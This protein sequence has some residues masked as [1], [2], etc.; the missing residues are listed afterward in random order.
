MSGVRGE[1]REIDRE[2]VTGKVCLDLA[3][4]GFHAAVRTSFCDGRRIHAIDQR[5]LQEHP[6]CVDVLGLCM[7][8][9][10]CAA[11]VLDICVLQLEA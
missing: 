4:R 11:V 1:R 6:E 9:A 5:E 7:G 8:R 3:G 10:G 2:C